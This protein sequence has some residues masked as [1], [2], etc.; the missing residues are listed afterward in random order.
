MGLLTA[1]VSIESMDSARVDLFVSI[2]DQTGQSHDISYFVPLGVSP[3]SFSVKEESSYDFNQAL[4]YDLDRALFQAERDQQHLLQALFAGTLLTNGVWLMPLWLPL[5]TGCGG[6]AGPVAVYSTESSTISVFDINETTDIDALVAVSGLDASVTDTLRRLRGQQIAVINMT[7]RPQA[8]S[9]GEGGEE[10]EGSGEP[11]LHLSWQ[12]S[13]TANS[14][15]AV[16]AYPLGT[17]AAWAQPI[18]LTRVYVVAPSELDLSI[19]FP[20]LGADHSGFD[21]KSFSWE[22]LILDYLDTPAYAVAH[23]EARTLYSAYGNQPLDIWRFS[24]TQSN[25]AEDIVITASQ[26]SGGGLGQSLRQGGMFTAFLVGLV[27]AALLWLLSWYLLMPRLLGRRGLAGLWY[28]PLVY[29]GVNL[30]LLVVPG[31]I[32]LVMLTF[33]MEAGALLFA[34]IIFGAAGAITFVLLDLKR[35][36]TSL[37]RAVISFLAVTLV[38]N[39]AYLLFALGYAYLAGAV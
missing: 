7:T 5:L 14:D 15:G 36:G 10:V 11:G 35:L 32:M 2:L 19:E 18:E 13:L 6:E 21:R 22:P 24:Y 27:A 12:A 23:A 29:M 8:A 20:K 39:A 9:D 34:F 4:T 25:A 33:G 31:I 17:G 16:Y 30:V 1:V 3:S 28:R 38:A 26:G 37:G